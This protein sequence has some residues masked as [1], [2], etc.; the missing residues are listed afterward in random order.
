MNWTII[1]FVNGK[2]LQEHKLM[3]L[4]EKKI[5]RKNEKKKENYPRM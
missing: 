2:T 1:S 3:L 5:S 4:S